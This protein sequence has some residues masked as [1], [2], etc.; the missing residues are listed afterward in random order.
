MGL[1]DRFKTWERSLRAS[2]N[3][4]LS[5]P[6]NRRRAAIHNAWFDHGI[7]RALWANFSEIAPGVYRSNHPT[8]RRFAKMKAMGIHTVLNLRGVSQ[9][10]QHWTEAEICRDL[11]L[12]LISIPLR[13]RAA[14][15]RAEIETLLKTF[16]TIDRPFVMHCKSGADRSGF[17]AA[18]WLMVMEG[19]PVEEARKM[20]S[21]RYI[22]FR[23]TKSG[24]LD[25]I[26]DSY[27]A[28]NARAPLPFADWIATEYDHAA[29]QDRFD[30]KVPAS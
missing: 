7:L 26:L 25:Y 6:E 21:P 1:K 8:R 11:D 2:Y 29:L 27:A 10:A 24:I 18:I 23:F 13:A 3:V 4:D 20:L 14:A 9:S 12:R 28:R 5:T 16:R 19:C 17:A 15:P 22:H 30:R